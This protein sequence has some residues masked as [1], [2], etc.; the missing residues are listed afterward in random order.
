MSMEVEGLEQVAEEQDC[1]SFILSEP[2]NLFG[3]CFVLQLAQSSLLPLF[4]GR[5]KLPVVFPECSKRA[6]FDE[7]HIGNVTI[8]DFHLPQ[9]VKT[10][11]CSR[12]R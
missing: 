7:N 2:H 1:F 9:R 4:R 8:S 11:I 12:S 3:R 5:W 10:T 6:E